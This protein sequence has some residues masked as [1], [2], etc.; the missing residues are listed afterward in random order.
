MKCNRRKHFLKKIIPITVVLFVLFSITTGAAN[1][2]SYVYDKNGKSVAEPLSYISKGVITGESLGVGNFNSPK[3]IFVFDNKLIY[4]VDTGNNRII[5]ID[6]DYKFQREISFFNN[7]G[8][9]DKLN[10]PNSIFRTEDIIYV[11][12]TG[13]KR[14]VLL[15]NS[16]NAI[17]VYGK[18]ES[19]LITEDFEYEPT[20]IV[21]DSAGRMFIVSKSVNDGI[22]ELSDK[23][24]FVGFI[25]A[26]KAKLTLFEKIWRAIASDSQREKMQL[27]LPTEH[28][29]VDIDESGFIYSTV[30][31]VNEDN[32]S[33]ETFVSRLNPMGKDVLKR[34]GFVAPMGDV[35]L[36]YEG[37]EKKYSM[38][39]DVAVRESGVYAV[40]DQR[41]GRVFTYNSNGE[42]MYVFGS[43]GDSEGQF[44][45]P[46]AIDTLNRDIFLV[47]DSQ[48]NWITIF[49]PT[50][51]GLIINDA[52]EC[53]YNRDY[54]KADD[55]WEEALKYTSQSGLAFD[56]LGRSYIKQGKYEASMD[57][58]KNADDRDNYSKAYEN[59][60]SEVLQRN[61]SLIIVI[62]ILI[63]VVIAVLRFVIK[64][65]RKVGR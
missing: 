49:T 41:R 38:L 5:E 8:K 12:D 23:G 58:L 31:A 28:S 4:I 26:V 18:P 21:A 51:Y 39:V 29:S 59:F 13:N 20:D 7:N 40:L 64:R 42:L 14:V 45:M 24:E 10:S 11:A 2:N 62:A 9:E 35:E 65:K 56:G 1:T 34:N 54:D 17:A 19:K 53:F 50:K 30:S 55:L 61:F 47:A 44:G 48:Y 43:L 33:P 6:A 32:Y 15:D 16:L 57:Y 37:S 22:I 63:I 27:S 36:E 25:G 3:D 60:R 52:I 46:E